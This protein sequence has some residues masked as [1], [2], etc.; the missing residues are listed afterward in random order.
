ME[1][2]TGRNG[3]LTCMFAGI[4]VAWVIASVLKVS[5]TPYNLQDPY[6]PFSISKQ[7]CAASA[8]LVTTMVS[9]RRAGFKGSARIP[10]GL[11]DLAQCRHLNVPIDE[12]AN[13]V[14]A[15]C[16][17]GKCM[18][19]ED[20]TKLHKDLRAFLDK[21]PNVVLMVFAPWCPHCHNAM[22]QFTRMAQSAKKTPFCIVNA[23]ALPRTAFTKGGENMIHALEYFPTFL[24]KKDGGKLE[25]K[26][27]ADVE[28]EAS[29]EESMGTDEAESSDVAEVTS[30]EVSEQTSQMLTQFF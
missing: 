26:D 5:S 30:P 4:L 2:S 14:V 18:T 25:E 16:K 17:D 12:K 1:Q 20:K 21:T 29:A 28:G 24:V 11:L 3:M 9:A 7:A 22:P 8:R 10:P 15:D 23:E 13:V 27:L 6:H 19:E